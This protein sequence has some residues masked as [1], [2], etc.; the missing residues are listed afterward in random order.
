MNALQFANRAQAGRALAAKLENYA[1]RDDVVVLALPRGGVPV[2]FEIAAYLRA[3]FDIMIVRKLG[4]P[5][6][7]E[8][9][10]GAIASGGFCVMNPDV[11]S[12]SHI[13]DSELREIIDREQRELERR[14]LAFRN[15]HPALNLEGRTVILV[16]DGIAT[17]AT[18]RAAIQAVHAQAPLRVIVAT[19]VAAPE[20]LRELAAEASEAVAVLTPSNL[21]SIGEWYFD[22]TQTSGEEVCSLLAKTRPQP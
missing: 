12:A 20:T 14:E 5:G 6:H 4:V 9:A 21:N 8:L 3:P 17:G 19:P 11:L 16:D 15:G 2:A 7:E 22:F 1:G 13:S 18:M 10:L